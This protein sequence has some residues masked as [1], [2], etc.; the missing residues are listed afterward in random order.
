LGH[1]QPLLV[2]HG[3]VVQDRCSDGRRKAP[4]CRDDERLIDS[5]H[6]D[7]GPRVA[8]KAGGQLDGSSGVG[9]AIHSDND[10]TDLTYAPAH[11]KNRH[12][13]AMDDIA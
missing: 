10:A 8:A 7:D 6:P 5:H 9:R 12:A 3:G 4:R 2:E 1:A 13:R 11:D